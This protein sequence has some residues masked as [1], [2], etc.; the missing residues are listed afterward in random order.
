MT[1]L[2]QTLK[3]CFEDSPMAFALLEPGRGQVCYLNAAAAK[4][5]RCPRAE[6]LRLSDVLGDATHKW[7]P[8]FCGIAVRGGDSTR[9]DSIPGGTVLRVQC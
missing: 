5:A 7:L 6:N 1:K 3:D 8:F 4:L 9:T 2:L